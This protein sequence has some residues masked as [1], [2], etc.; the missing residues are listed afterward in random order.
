[1]VPNKLLFLCTGN[2]Y[3]S[4]F[5]EHW[6]NALANQRGLNWCAESRGLGDD[7]SV[8]PGPIAQSALQELR[9]RGVEVPQPYRMP[10]HATAHDFEH[11]DCVIALKET[12][13][14]P[15][16]Q[17]KFPVWENRI[18][19]WHIHDLDVWS[20]SQGLGRLADEILRFINTLL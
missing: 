18:A 17:A 9:E 5:A 1:M 14:R 13:H 16:M 11:A 19:Y 20:S 4:R 2:Y 6:F 7:L 15:M 8:N 3:R 12:E 10:L